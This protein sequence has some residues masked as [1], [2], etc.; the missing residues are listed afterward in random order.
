MVR[1]AQLTS[2]PA[3]QTAAGPGEGEEGWAPG[4]GHQSCSAIAAGT[5]AAM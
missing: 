5:Q 2:M 1:A 3:R 4:A